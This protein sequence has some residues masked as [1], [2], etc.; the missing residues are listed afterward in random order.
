MLVYRAAIFVAVVAAVGCSRTWVKFKPYSAAAPR[1][2]AVMGYAIVTYEGDIPALAQAEGY[3]IGSL[4]VDGNGFANSEDVRLRATVEAAEYGGTHVVV[5]NE[6][7]STSWAQISPDRATTT[8]QGNT[9]TAR[10]PNAGRAAARRV[11]RRSRAPTPL[12]RLAC[13]DTSDPGHALQGRVPS[14]TQREWSAW[15]RHGAAYGRAVDFDIRV[16]MWCRRR[17]TRDVLPNRGHVQRLPSAT[18]K[19]TRHVR[20]AQGGALL[21]V[22]QGGTDAVVLSPHNRG[23]P[24]LSGLRVHER[25]HDC[26]GVH[27]FAVRPLRGSALRLLARRL[28]GWKC[29]LLSRAKRLLAR[30][31]VRDLRCG[32]SRSGKSFVPV[33]AHSS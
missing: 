30:V 4:E 3:T 26:S 11:H 16:V 10:H 32:S 29:S 19:A 25:R 33:V 8:F 23:M 12:A 22:R 18:R 27:P 31:S 28:R 14:S 13:H 2:P 1:A 7:S 9:A 17:P 15:R 20:W 21:L 6:G 5:A 24:R